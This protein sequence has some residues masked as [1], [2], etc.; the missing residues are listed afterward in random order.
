MKN[1]EKVDK[2]DQ[3][4][5]R[6]KNTEAKKIY[7]ATKK[8]FKTFGK[9]LEFV[10]KFN[11]WLIGIGFYASTLWLVLKSLNLLRDFGN[12]IFQIAGIALCIF[13]FLF[14][15]LFYLSKY[16]ASIISHPRKFLIFCLINLVTLLI[17]HG[18]LN[19][20]ISKY[21]I[22]AALTG[23]LLASFIGGRE[24][25]SCVIILGGLIGFISNFSIDVVFTFIIMGGLASLS[26]PFMHKRLDL[27]KIG[28]ASGVMGAAFIISWGLLQKWDIKMILM[29]SLFGMG[30]ALASAFLALEILPFIE[31]LFGK[32]NYVKLL[33]LSQLNHPL[34]VNLK[35]KAPGSYQSCLMVANLAEAAAEEIR[36]NPLLARV[37]AYY[38]DIGKIKNPPYFIENLNINSKSRHEKVNPALS[39]L[40]LLSHVKEGVQLAEKYKLPREI[41]DIIKQHHGTTLTSFFYQEALKKDSNGEIEEE[42]FRYPGPTPQSK[43]AAIVMLSDTIEAASRTLEDPSPARIRN[44]VEN[45]VKEKLMGGQLDESQLNFKDLHLIQKSFVQTLTGSF[46][47]RIKYP[48]SEKIGEA[49]ENKNGNNNTIERKEKS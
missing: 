6:S 4:G 30:G 12:N 8:K 36:A 21:S 5:V 3:K 37:G 29:Q 1:G 15:I 24:A 26:M 42:S 35:E 19:A 44:M 17:A 23:M 43:E 45:L 28:F 14:I 40:I 46:H 18:I 7:F 32:L 39:R 25:L 49:Q 38:H 47:N 33:E 41:R 34:L 10:R 13:I 48:D 22:P 2:V 27:F 11:L 31:N 16:N 9:P 20:N